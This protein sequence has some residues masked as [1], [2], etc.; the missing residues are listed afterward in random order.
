[1]GPP[2]PF[3]AGGLSNLAVLEWPVDGS[4][5][6]RATA[7]QSGLRLVYRPGDQNSLVFSGGAI[8]LR[9]PGQENIPQPIS[10]KERVGIPTYSE[11]K[12]STC[13]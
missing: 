13:L 5:S 10:F 8:A 12:H 7:E 4:S 11:A 3:T 2:S 1:M 6:G 9:C